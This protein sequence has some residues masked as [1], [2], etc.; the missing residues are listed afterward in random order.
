MT[1]IPILSLLIFFP[2]IGSLVILLINK[3][4]KYYEKKVR[5]IGLWTSIINFLL[6]LILLYLFDQTEDQFQFVENF[7]KR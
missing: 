6:S 5:E 2:L 3:K 7:K 1:N 4:D